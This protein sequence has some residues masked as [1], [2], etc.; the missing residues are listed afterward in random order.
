VNFNLKLATLAEP[1]QSWRIVRSVKHST[2]WD[3]AETLFE[4]SF[5]AFGVLAQECFDLA[6]QDGTVLPPGKFRRTYAIPHFTAEIGTRSHAVVLQGR[7]S[8]VGC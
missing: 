1:E 2:V 3:G 5:L 6:F 8:E 4:F 7:G